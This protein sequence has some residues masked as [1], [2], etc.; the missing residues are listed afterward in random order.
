MDYFSFVIFLAVR[1]NKG[2]RTER[3]HGYTLEYWPGPPYVIRVMTFG[4]LQMLLYSQSSGVAQG[5]APQL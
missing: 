3:W 1:M 5:V 4:L 2:R